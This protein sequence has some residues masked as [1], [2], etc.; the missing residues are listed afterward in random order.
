MLLVVGVVGGVLLLGT[1]GC[2]K[3]IFTLKICL[4][5]LEIIS[6]EVVVVVEVVVASQSQAPRL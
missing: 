6:V 2:V 4:V 3:L 1:F 5:A